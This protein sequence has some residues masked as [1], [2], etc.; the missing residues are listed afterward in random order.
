MY[1]TYAEYAEMGGA[2][3]CA[4]FTAYENEAEILIDYYSFERLK[5]FITIPERVKQLVFKLVF[6]SEKDEDTRGKASE[7]NGSYS[8]SYRTSDERSIETT[9]LIRQYLIGVKTADGTPLLYKGV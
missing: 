5:S 3:D 9:A 8:V 4:A 6:L 1:L 7:S 2:L